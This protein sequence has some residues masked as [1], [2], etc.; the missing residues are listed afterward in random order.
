MVDP[1]TSEIQQ[2]KQ[3][4]DSDI[5][6]DQGSSASTRILAVVCA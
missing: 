5:L 3:V 6:P 2:R 4:T 1:C